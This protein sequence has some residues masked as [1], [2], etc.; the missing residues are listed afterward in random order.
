MS[1]PQYRICREPKDTEYYIEKFIQGEGYPVVIKDDFKT[2]DEAQKWL[3]ENR[4]QVNHSN[5]YM[6]KWQ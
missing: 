2:I 3:D 5:F 1:T 4:E 6:G